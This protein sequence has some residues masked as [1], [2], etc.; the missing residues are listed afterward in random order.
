[1]RRYAALVGAVLALTG[2]PAQAKGPKESF[3]TLIHETEDGKFRTDRMLGWSLY[4]AQSE[5]G[6]ITYDSDVVGVT[7]LRDPV[8]LVAEDVETLRLGIMIY[9]ADPKTQATVKYQIIDGRIVHQ[10]TGVALSASQ[11]KTVTKAITKVQALL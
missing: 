11:E 9:L 4:A 2:Q 6:D 8:A 3:C 5:P 1:M 7:C 10:A